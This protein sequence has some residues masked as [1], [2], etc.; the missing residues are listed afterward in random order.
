MGWLFC[1]ERGVITP[2]DASIQYQKINTYPNN[3][4]YASEIA[5]GYI[6]FFSHLLHL[7]ECLM[8]VD[9]RTHNLVNLGASDLAVQEFCSVCSRLGSLLLVN[10]KVDDSSLSNKA[11]GKL[12][13]IY[14]CI[15]NTEMYCC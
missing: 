4:S 2:C 6:L 9:N 1:L 3:F 10:L 13:Y 7:V 12:K 8:L 15:S 5:A 11:P 14:I